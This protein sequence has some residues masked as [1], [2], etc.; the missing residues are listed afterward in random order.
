M[1]ERENLVPVD[2]P[3]QQLQLLAAEMIQ[4]KDLLADRVE[5]LRSLTYEDM[6]GRQDIRALLS[7]YERALQTSQRAMVDMARLGIE[8]RLVRLSEA[9]AELI[10]GSSWPCSTAARWA[11]QESCAR[12]GAP[13]SPVNSRR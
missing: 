9:Q 13:S 6:S 11:C 5:M 4:Y 2:N 3:L 7:A 10:K 12:P 1:L 8:E